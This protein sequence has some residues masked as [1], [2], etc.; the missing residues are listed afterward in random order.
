MR[1]C[2]QRHPLTSFLLG[3]GPVPIVE[4]RLGV[5]PRPV[6]TV[7]SPPP[8]FDPRTAR[9]VACR[10]TDWDIP[11]SHTFTVLQTSW[12]LDYGLEDSVFESRL[13]QEIFFCSKTSRL[14]LES[15]EP[16]LE[17]GI[18]VL[19]RRYSS[20]RVNLTTYLNSMKWWRMSGA[21]VSDVNN[22][23]LPSPAKNY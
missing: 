8:G 1:R 23:S 11:A 12:W 14:A 9:L 19:S 17:F 3:K 21:I 10:C 4:R 2:G 7:L 6:W 13:R 18:G 15:S 20:R 16:A 5:D 22:R